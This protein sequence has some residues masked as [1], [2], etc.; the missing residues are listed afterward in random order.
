MENASHTIVNFKNSNKLLNWN[1]VN[2]AVMGGNSKS[3]IDIDTGGYAI[4]KGK[5]SLKNNGGFSFLRH[6]FDKIDVSN[7]SK[8]KIHL[9][10]D[11][12]RYQFR[13]KSDQSN[14][15]SYVAY[16]TTSSEW[17]TVQI[18]LCDLEPKYRGK[19]LNMDNYSGEELD[20]I[21]F[22]IANKM[23]ESFK[24]IINSISLE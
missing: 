12:K 8:I 18:N 5:V 13:V 7:F 3:S 1:V 9:K 19:K 20:E 17:E 10:G 4:F 15:H 24:L 11:G 23:E 2:D 16:F 6:R 22:L 21:G 14:Q